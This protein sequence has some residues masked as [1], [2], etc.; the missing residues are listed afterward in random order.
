[1]FIYAI[2]ACVDENDDENVFILRKYQYTFSNAQ[3]MQCRN[4]SRN[5]ERL[6][7]C[8]NMEYEVKEIGLIFTLINFL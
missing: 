3:Y 7:H 5:I 1:M 4:T 6:A 8:R 2:K